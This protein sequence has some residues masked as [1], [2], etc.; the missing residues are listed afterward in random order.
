MRSG[1]FERDTVQSSRMLWLLSRALLV[2]MKDQKEF[3]RASFGTLFGDSFEWVEHIML[4]LESHL[5][6]V[7]TKHIENCK[8]LYLVWTNLNSFERE[9]QHFMETLPDLVEKALFS[10]SLY[11]PYIPRLMKIK[12]GIIPLIREKFV[13]VL[14]LNRSENSPSFFL[15]FQTTKYFSHQNS[16]LKRQGSLVKVIHRKECHEHVIYRG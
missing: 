1:W 15:A 7:R 8:T 16:D 13:I 9:L 14:V 4:R 11:K 3:Q 6:C 2:R 10:P 5:E 12:R